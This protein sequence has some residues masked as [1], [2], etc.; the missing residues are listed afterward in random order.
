[1]AYPSAL[2]MNL[3]N[4]WDKPWDPRARRSKAF[5]S[6]LDGHGYLTP[7][8]T[9]AEARCKDGTDV[10][11][12]QRA[13]ARN[14]A[15]NL[16]RLRHRL[17]DRPIAV[18]SWYRTVAHN[19]EVGG[20]SGSKHIEAI[21]TDHPREW[22]DATGRRSVMAHGEVIFRQGGMGVYPWGAVHFDTRGARARWNSWG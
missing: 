13:R 7:H 11:R 16:E 10:P 15:F 22:V 2:P 21:A 3:R 17:G 1:M 5:R 20:A 4:L 8:F 9:L 12:A 19:K 14:H 6:W 18:I